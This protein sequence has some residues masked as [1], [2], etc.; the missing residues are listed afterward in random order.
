MSRVRL[1][2]VIGPD[3]FVEVRL[4]DCRVPSVGEYAITGVSVVESFVVKY[5]V[6]LL[7][8]TADVCVDKLLDEWVL[9]SETMVD[10]YTVVRKIEASDL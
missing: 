8:L 4:L 1:V 2:E 3:I 5:L 7:S 6:T 9:F 10:R